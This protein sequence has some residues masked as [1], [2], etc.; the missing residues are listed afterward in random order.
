M[1]LRITRTDTLVDVE[2]VTCRIWKGFDRNGITCEVYVFAIASDRN[3]SV[4]PA[5]A[6]QLNGPIETGELE[7]FPAP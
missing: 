6:A 2:G 4:H 1:E 3:A 7:H 5:I